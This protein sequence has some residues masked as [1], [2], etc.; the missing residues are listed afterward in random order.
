M[1]AGRPP[2]STEAHK[3]DGTF[4]P[5]RHADIHQQPRGQLLTAMPS[6][7]GTLRTA[8][9][10]YYTKVCQYL[11]SNNALYDSDLESI[12][13]MCIAYDIVKAS[14]L[15]MKKG[16]SVTIEVA[17]GV[18][19]VPNPAYAVWKQASGELSKYQTLFGLNPSSRSRIKLDKPKED[20]DPIG[21]LARQMG[22]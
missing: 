12:E 5:D 14:V 2:K 21:E 9:R 1:P 11:I 16:I 20:E 19:T 15:E 8:G 6:K 13:A 10:A 18:R 7:P 3:R 22:M 4:R 17:S